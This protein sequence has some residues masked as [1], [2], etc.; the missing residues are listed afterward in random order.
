MSLPPYA[1]ASLPTR[2]EKKPK[3]SFNN[4]TKKL[5][6][7]RSDIKEVNKEINELE[8]Q[9]KLIDPDSTGKIGYDDFRLLLFS[10]GG[11]LFH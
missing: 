2:K 11:S 4:L 8:K 9:L 7:L 1:I 6:G 5:E 3:E 10:S